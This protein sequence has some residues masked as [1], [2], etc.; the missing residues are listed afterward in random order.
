VRHVERL[1]QRVGRPTCLIEQH[2]RTREQHQRPV[3]ALETRERPGL[4]DIR[5][6]HAPEERIEARALRIGGHLAGDTAA[7][8]P[9]RRHQIGAAQQGDA[10]GLCGGLCRGLRGNLFGNHSRG[11]GGPGIH[12]RR[13]ERIRRVDGHAP[14]HDQRPSIGRLSPASRAVSCA[15]S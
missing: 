8:L 14:R 5:D 13:I 15:S 2:T 10:G 9:R 4:R 6:A 3:D 1:R 11:T 7:V 12:S